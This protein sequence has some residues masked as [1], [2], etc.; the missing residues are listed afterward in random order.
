MKF[1]A[2]QGVARQGKGFFSVR[3][4]SK[5]IYNGFKFCCSND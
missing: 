5:E 4:F 1:Y 3:F 2:G